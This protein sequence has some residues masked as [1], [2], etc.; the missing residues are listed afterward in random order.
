MAAHETESTQPEQTLKSLYLEPI[1]KAKAL[2]MID[3]FEFHL[4]IDSKTE[5]YSTLDQIVKDASEFGELL[6]SS[7]NPNGLKLIISVNR[8]K[9]EDYSLYPEWI[10]FDYQSKE[11]TNSLPWEKKGMVSLSFM[12]FSVWNGKGRV[13]ETEKSRLVEFINLVHSFQK[14]VRFW[15]SPDGKTA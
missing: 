4:L 5:A 10:F 15:A 9:T 8:P 13:V 6:L 2:G 14:P 7:Q 12:Q 3:S 1:Q 11:L